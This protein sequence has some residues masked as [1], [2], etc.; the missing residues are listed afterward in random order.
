MTTDDKG[1]GVMTSLIAI[2]RYDLIALRSTIMTL[3]LSLE[4]FILAIL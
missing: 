1:G 2:P 4:V 3:E